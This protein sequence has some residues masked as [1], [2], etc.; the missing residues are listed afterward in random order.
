[1]HTIQLHRFRE[2]REHLSKTQ[3]FPEHQWQ[4]LALTVVH[5]PRPADSGTEA[6]TRSEAWLHC[7]SVLESGFTARLF[8]RN[9]QEIESSRNRIVKK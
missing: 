8:L 9:R 6:Q 5:V 2:E 7:A 1:M 4:N 3:L